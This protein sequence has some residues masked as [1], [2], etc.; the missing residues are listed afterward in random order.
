MWTGVLVPKAQEVIAEQIEKSSFLH[1]VVWVAGKKYE[2][3]EEMTHIVDLDARSCTC[4]VWWNSGLPCT[5]ASAA[6]DH[7]HLQITDFCEPYFTVQAYRTTYA[8]EFCPVP[9]S[10][11]LTG[12]LN[13]TVYPPNTKRPRQAD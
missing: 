6:I 4:R 10:M 7:C 11:P 13:R 9:D 12:E 2:I 3:H 1:T 5:H 8:T